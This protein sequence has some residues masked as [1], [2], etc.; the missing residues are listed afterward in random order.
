M[1]ALCGMFFFFFNDTATTEIYT[2]SLHDA[3]PICAAPGHQLAQARAEPHRRRVRVA[4]RGLHRRL[5]R[6]GP[7][8]PRRAGDRHLLSSRGALLGDPGLRYRARRDPGL[9]HVLLTAPLRVAPPPLAAR[10]RG[11]R[12]AAVRAAAEGEASL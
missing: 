2:L 10:T 12:A 4:R 6:L 8:R 7:E 11:R 3:L 9:S 5:R 1:L